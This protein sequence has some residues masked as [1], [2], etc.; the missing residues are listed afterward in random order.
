MKKLQVYMRAASLLRWATV[1][2][3][4]SLL[5]WSGWSQEIGAVRAAREAAGWCSPGAWRDYTNN[6]ILAPGSSGAWDAGALET[7]AVAKVGNLWHLYYEGWAQNGDGSLGA[8]AIGHA[9]SLDAVNWTKDPANPVLPASTNDW[10]VAA[11]DPSLIYEDGLFKLWHGG[12]RGDWGYATSTDGTHFVE[13]GQLSHLG[14]CEDDHVFHD[15]ASGKYFMY[16]WN[17]QYEPEGLYC[18]ISPNETN[19]NFA[20]AVP[21]HIQ[22]LPY[23]NTMYK[24]PHVFKDGSQWFMYFG[25]FIRPGCAGCWTGYATSQDGLNWQLQNAQLIR[26]HDAFVLPLT[27]NL[28]LM[29]YCPDGLF[30]QPADD[31]RLAVYKGKLSALGRNGK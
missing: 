21:I 2:F 3:V 13:H 28:Y 7:M 26:C 29:Y 10:C 12:N 5:G 20:G 23:T 27:N 4:V 30:D 1:T 19:F 18:A 22:G 6:P 8:I 15:P 25:E 9:T 14:N 31:I 11:W 16:Y 24:F 17:R